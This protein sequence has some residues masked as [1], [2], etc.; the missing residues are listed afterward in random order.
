MKITVVGGT[1]VFGSRL[2]E[3]LIRD[4]H[5]VRI[6]ARSADAVTELARRIGATPLVVDIHAAPEA[7]FLVS[8]RCRLAPSCS[9]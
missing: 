3:L 5:E 9:S 7:V 1:G 4:G 2:A 8:S 6:A